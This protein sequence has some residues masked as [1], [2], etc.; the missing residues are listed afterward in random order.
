MQKYKKNANH[1]KV[2]TPNVFYIEEKASKLLQKLMRHKK[3]VGKSC[4]TE[5]SQ[6]G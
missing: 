2:F 4:Y 3:K 5:K 1:L 6:I